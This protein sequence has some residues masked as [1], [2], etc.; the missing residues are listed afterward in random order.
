MSGQTERDMHDL[1][2][3]DDL[4]TSLATLKLIL[5]DIDK[6]SV[7]IDLEI[8]NKIK[9]LEA[10]KFNELEMLEEELGIMTLRNKYH[11][12][13]N[14]IEEELDLKRQKKKKIDNIE[15]L[16]EEVKEREFKRVRVLQNLSFEKNDQIVEI[17][18]MELK[19]QRLGASKKSISF[20]KKSIIAKKYLRLVLLTEKKSV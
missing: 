18:K 16:K 8:N 6:I 10:E 13:P 7:V 19:L 20:F 9:Q 11:G 14:N 15:E 2:T 17:A 12:R 1:T 5:E 3:Y 4:I